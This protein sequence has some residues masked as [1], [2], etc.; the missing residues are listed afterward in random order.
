MQEQ[1]FFNKTLRNI[2][3]ISTHWIPFTPYRHRIRDGLFEKM[4]AA[5][6]RLL[7]SQYRKQYQE[8]LICVDMA[9]SLGD[10][11]QA[12]HYLQKFGLREFASPFDWMMCYTLKDIQNLFAN[13]FEGF[14][15]DIQE[16]EDWESEN[17]CRYITDLR[18]GMV[19]IHA[20][21]Q[22]QSIQSQY[23]FFIQTMQRRFANLK[24]HIFQSQH[25]L[26]VTT[27][28]SDKESCEEFLYFMQSYHNA[29]Y[30]ILN[31]AKMQGENVLSPAQKKITKLNA[32]LSIIDYS[33]VDT[34]P[35]SV[36]LQS[37]NTA[38]TTG[39]ATP[40]N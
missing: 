10:A 27:R 17:G 40:F 29:N 1:I 8:E 33:F 32:K 6:N 9:I 16:K 39:G 13:D 19:S 12:A 28:P 36:L 21:K 15:A 34:Y 37:N 38:K 23:S 35:N 22:A 18:N 11:C 7:L 24:S 30:T 26:F 20:F 3:K 14:F 5:F 2:S 4:N 25:I 31:I